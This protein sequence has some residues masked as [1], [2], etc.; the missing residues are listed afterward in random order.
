M[1][2]SI[3]ENAAATVPGV[4]PPPR[5]VVRAA[6]ASALSGLVGFIPLHLVWALGIPFGADADRFADWYDTGGGSYL[7][8]LN[9][10]AVLPSV[11]AVG[12]VRPWGLRFPA[13]V[14]GVAGRRVPRMLM[15]VPGVGVSVLLFGYTLFAAV[16]MVFIWDSPDAIFA[17]WT[18]FYGIAQFL[19]W[20]IGLAVATRSYAVRT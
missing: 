19:V 14:P 10:L 8:L 1:G 9:A 11:V 2:P 12:L 3:S 20:A 7:F 15:I 17:P 4:D 6:Y 18:V 13:W 5:G 16:L